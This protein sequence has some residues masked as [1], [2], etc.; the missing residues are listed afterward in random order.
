MNR[1][2]DGR[3]L[4]GGC[5]IGDLLGFCKEGNSVCGMGVSCCYVMILLARSLDLLEAACLEPLLYLSP[6]AASPPFFG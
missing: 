4:G 1:G 5:G 6:P 2:D 3:N